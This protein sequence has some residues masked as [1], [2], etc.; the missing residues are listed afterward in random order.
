MD[1]N[2]ITFD[3]HNNGYLNKRNK[4]FNINFRI[5][6]KY[7]EMSA[8]ILNNDVRS[9][10]THVKLSTARETLGLTWLSTL[11]TNSL[12]VSQLLINEYIF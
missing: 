8:A 6:L 11:N 9:A 2:K 7:R 1:A 3:V 10:K 12:I 5:T 4:S